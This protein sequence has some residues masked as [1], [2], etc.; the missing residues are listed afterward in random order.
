[1]RR[2]A[3]LGLDGL[4]HVL[5]FV[6]DPF[7]LVAA[8]DCA[9]L[10]SVEREQFEMDGERLEVH[11]TEGLPR[12]VLEAMSLGVPVVAT[13]VEGVPE[14]IEEGVNG[15][16]VRPSDAAALAAALER[17]AGDPGWREAAGTAG[18]EIVRVKFTIDASAA[19][20]A[21]VLHEVR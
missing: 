1:L 6:A 9:V 14:Q 16:T 17:V 19:G 12:S 2:R 3:E 11:G 15:I 8:A 7:G 21:A 18:R 5:G 10:P 20:L 13:R 4:V